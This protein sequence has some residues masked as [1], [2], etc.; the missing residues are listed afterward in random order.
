MTDRRAI[1]RP[2]RRSSA[3]LAIVFG[4]AMSAPAYTLAM[5]NDTAARTGTFAADT[6]APPTGLAA[7][8]A[9]TVTLSW[10]PTVDTYAAGYTVYRGTVSGGPYT[11]I[12]TLSPRTVATTTDTPGTGTFYYVLQ[13]TFGS[14]TSVSSNQASITIGSPT[15]TTVK[16]CTT[17]AADTT[18]AG[19]NNG[20]ETN[21]ARVCA[22]DGSTATDASSGSAWA[23]ASCGS[24]ATPATAKDRH[25]FWGYAF[26]LPGTVT[27]ITG[28]T[29]RADLGMN[30][31]GGTTNLC[32]QL[33]WDG[34]STWTTIKTLAVS[35]TGQSAYTF[36]GTTDPW[37]RTWSLGEFSTTNFR[38]RIIDASTQSNKNFL[39]D[40]VG[41][42]VTY[43]P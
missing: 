20:Y 22:D 4:L 42:S 31:N 25:R 6:L 38:V 17:T 39:L 36:G 33:S 21:P 10:T 19:D 23:D 3:V 34:G 1:R 35:G 15:T 28:I 29:V 27:S 5:F 12:G 40:Y 9:P 30:N 24:G 2:S 41:V 26:G 37:G 13:S 8:N 14:W 11:S 7:A 32:A 18:N 16:S 43:Y